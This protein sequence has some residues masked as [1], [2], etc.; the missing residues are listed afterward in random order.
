MLGRWGNSGSDDTSAWHL[1]PR[2][3]GG[4][5]AGP[6]LVGRTDQVTMFARQVVAYPDGVELEI[7]A[8]ARGPLPEGASDEDDD[9]QDDE[10]G[11]IGHVGYA[12][13]GGHR[14]LRFHVRFGD[15]R[16]AALDDEAGLRSGLGPM[17]SVIAGETSSG[18]PHGEDVRQR[19]WIWPLPP[20]GP[21]TLTCSWPRR[22]LPESVI[23]LDGDAIRAAAERATPF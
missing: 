21:F 20:S 4:Y 1:P 22:D 9:D 16:E 12:R 5:V 7:E 3:I 13:L 17:V 14:Q 18:G 11:H 8:H 23:V 19:L 15:G 6:L 2:M 10:P